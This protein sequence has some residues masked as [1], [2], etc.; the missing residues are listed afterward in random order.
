[1]RRRTLLRMGQRVGVRHIWLTGSVARGDA[2]RG[3]DVDL[4]IESD[5]S[6]DVFLLGHWWTAVLGRQVDVLHPTLVCAQGRKFRAS[7][8]RDA[9]PLHHYRRGATP[10]VPRASLSHVALSLARRHKR[11]DQAGEG[12]E[13]AR[14]SSRSVKRP[15]S[16][17]RDNLSCVP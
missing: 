8:W 12:Q 17:V 10:V 3:S 15:R 5:N 1:M 13:N 4:L 7:V 2:A 9:I 6:F 16:G 11:L 14:R